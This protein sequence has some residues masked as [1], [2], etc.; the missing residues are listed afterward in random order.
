[1]FI[2]TQ[3]V[4]GR[5]PHC[6]SVVTAKKSR[7]SSRSSGY[8]N[9]PHLTVLIQFGIGSDSHKVQHNKSIFRHYLLPGVLLVQCC[10]VECVVALV[11]AQ[12]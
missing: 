8:N 2:K 7:V 12:L 6:C 4:N 3:K 1:M 10:L 5:P 11:R 9:T